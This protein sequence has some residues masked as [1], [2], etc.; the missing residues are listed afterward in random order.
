MHVH[1]HTHAHV[2]G[3]KGQQMWKKLSGYETE[4]NQI[5]VTAF[6]SHFFVL[7]IYI[8]TLKIIHMTIHL[9]MRLYDLLGWTICASPY[10]CIKSNKCPTESEHFFIALQWS[11][12]TLLLWRES[13]KL[14]VQIQR[15]SSNH[16]FIHPLNYCLLA[17]ISNTRLDNDNRSMPHWF[18]INCYIHFKPRSIHVTCCG[19]A[20][21]FCSRYYPT[22]TSNVEAKKTVH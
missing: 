6:Y 16:I 11:E 14:D 2:C 17:Y 22:E 13:Q 20:L 7:Y 10:N 9:N 19:I 12:S 3:T 21:D 4:V 18:G 1:V 15:A 5:Y 8:Y